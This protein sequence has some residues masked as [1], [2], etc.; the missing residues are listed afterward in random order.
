MIVLT[1][2][3]GGT[4]IKLGRAEVS[5]DA[6]EIVESAVLD[7]ASDRGLVARLPAV[8]EALWALNPGGEAVGLGVCFAS[9]TVGDRVTTSFGKYE[10]APGV[11]LGQWAREA[12]GLKLTLEND[13][14]AAAVGEWRYGAGRGSD[15]QVMVTLGTGVGTCP[16]IQGRPLRGKHG[17]AGILGGHLAIPEGR[18][19]CTCGSIG[20]GEA[21]TGTA[22]LPRRAPDRPDLHDY[23]AVFVA[24]ERGDADAARLRDEALR[25]WGE[26][27]VNLIHA[28]DPERL[29]VGGGVM[30]SR[31]M[32]LPAVQ[33]WVDDY[34][35]TPWGRVEVVAAE[36]GDAAG[37]LGVARLAA[38]PYFNPG[39]P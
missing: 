30:G 13:A 24:A 35:C 6:A 22:T 26:I 9:I 27:A 36:L 29:I 8:S 37:L 15:D 3:M 28:Y 14:R 25:G 38:E 33:R 12:L 34:A 23:A 4:R 11:D 19:P 10:D 5:A 7:A 31:D 21:A 39:D 1:A 16:I 18:T 17:Q 2:D 20:C 32:I